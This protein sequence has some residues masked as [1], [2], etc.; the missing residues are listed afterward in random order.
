MNY[1]INP[2]ISEEI[3]GR[4]TDPLTGNIIGTIAPIHEAQLLSY[5]R[6]YGTCTRGL[7]INFNVKRLVDG[8]CRMK[9]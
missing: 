5:L 7:L 1:L 9:I 8:I 2:D 6:L 3:D 4:E